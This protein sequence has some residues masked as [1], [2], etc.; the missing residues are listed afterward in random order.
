M[1]HCSSEI[2]QHTKRDHR[3][4]CTWRRLSALIGIRVANRQLVFHPQ[5]GRGCT[6]P[7][8]LPAPPLNL[9]FTILPE[10]GATCLLAF[11]CWTS[12]YSIDDWFD[13][14][15]WF[16]WLILISF[17]KQVSILIT[18]TSFLVKVWL[19]R[20]NVCPRYTISVCETLWSTARFNEYD[21][22]HFG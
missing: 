21:L 15:N 17:N 14:P 9:D 6:T 16:V 19:F 13:L 22:R 4:S 2:R 18:A 1:V 10:F 7:R 11:R 12:N 20:W 5:A 8:R 3:L